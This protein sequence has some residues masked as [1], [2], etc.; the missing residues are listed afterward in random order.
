[1]EHIVYK[2][3]KPPRL[4][5]IPMRTIPTNQLLVPSSTQIIAKTSFELARRQDNKTK[6]SPF[7]NTLTVQLT[8]CCDTFK[9]KSLH[10]QEQYLHTVLKYWAKKKTDNSSVFLIKFNGP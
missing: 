6:Q 5:T 1:M 9:F 8:I 10:W 3:E 2:A 4:N 7:N